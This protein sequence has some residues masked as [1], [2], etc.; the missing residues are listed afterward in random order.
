MIAGCNGTAE[1]SPTGSPSA[2]PTATSGTTPSP[3]ASPTR[4]PQPTPPPW[5]AGWETGFC[6]AFAE[7][8]IA[9]ELVVDVPRALEEEATD[10]ALGLSRELR[11]TAPAAAELVSGVDEWET[12]QPTLGAMLAVLDIAERIGR[13]YTRYFEEDRNASLTRAVELTEEIIP[14]VAESND[15]LAD[16]AALGIDCPQSSLMLESPPGP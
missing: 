6:S 7:T 4:T 12:A 1:R 3:L 14:L 5:P 9:M 13:Q 15:G 16:L 11:D 2:L 10:D 8:A